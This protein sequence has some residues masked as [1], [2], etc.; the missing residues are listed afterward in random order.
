MLQANDL[1]CVRGERALFA[2]VS[3]ALAAGQLLRIAG[4]NG[5]GKTS[6][7]RILCGLL[8]PTEGE[9]RWND[10]PVS[11]LREEFR[12]K[13]VYVGH[14]NGI[15]DDLTP[16][17]NL[18]TA[19]TLAGLAPDRAAQRAALDA[20]GLKH[21]AALP[22]RHLS[23]GQRRRVA[24]ARLVLAS[25]V[26]LWILDEPFTALD[27]QALGLVAQL[28]AKHLAHGGMVVLTTHLEVAINAVQV[29]LVDLDL[30]ARRA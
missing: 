9:V 16:L 12:R 20:F 1:A 7:L 14:P 24:L 4:A 17:E 27:A 10:E 19:A 3:F 26:P 15:K 23:Q 25:A 22:A 6:L 11:A 21:C 30:Q 29:V 28:I 8:T 13:L 18:D 2:R 5:S